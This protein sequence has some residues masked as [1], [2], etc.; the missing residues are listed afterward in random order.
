MNTDSG[1]R[2]IDLAGSSYD[3]G[4]QHGEI[5][6]DDIRDFY[7]SIWEIHKANNPGL[8]AESSELIGFCG[9]NT[10]FIREYSAELF[11]EL[12]GIADGSG[13]SVGQIIYL[14]SFLELEDLRAPGLGGRLLSG[15]LW[16]CTTFNVLPEASVEGKCLIGQTFDM[17]KYYSRFNVLLRITPRSGPKMIVYSFAGVLGLNGMNSKGIGS[18]INKVVAADAAPGVIFPVI[19]RTL[20]AQERIG[21]AL[22]SAV[23]AP[24]ASGIIYQLADN[25]GVAFCAET[26]TSRY[27][28]LPL[29]GAMAHTNHYVES[30][31]KELET[32]GW[33][34]H[35]GSFV[36]YQVANRFL[37]ANLGKIDVEL[38]MNLTRDHTNYPR[39]ICA[40]G[41]EGE[42]EKVAFHTVA[43]M[44]MNLSEPCLWAC[45][46][47]P[48]VNSYER[49][50]FSK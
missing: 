31:M 11:E 37:Q 28:L 29:S 19:M 2:V 24:R 50:T 23:F 32:P 36:R 41:S 22:G 25:N 12:Q 30:S 34:T 9:R 10:G 45:H 33:L 35:G 16:G 48:C 43:A 14:N 47:N 49:V 40:H 44:V 1:I 7:D 27:E 13:L 6:K 18:V 21:D 20:L 39:S 5:L 46:G 8:K 15:G 4:R 38:L 3:I 42:D 26:S 17:E